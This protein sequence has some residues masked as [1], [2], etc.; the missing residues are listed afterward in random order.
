MRM[1]ASLRSLFSAL[2]R[3]SGVE[4]DM[5]EEL[6]T[7][8]QNRADDLERSGVPRSEAERRARIEFGGQERF[9]EEIREALGTHFLEV[10]LQDLRFGL[11]ML[12]KSPGFTAVAVLTLALGIGANTAIFSVVNAV[13]LRPMPFKDPGRLVIVWHTPPQKSFPGIATFVV[14]P[15]NF[16][17]WREQNHVFEQMT[18]VGFGNYNLTGMGQPE[19][20]SGVA[21]SSEFFPLLGIRPVF[22]RDFLPEEDQPGK[23]DVVIISNALCHSHF[24]D[25]H[26]ALGKT[27]LL[28]GH[29][30]LVIGVMP[31]QFDFPY[32]ADFWRPLAWSDKQR[33]VRGDH[34][35]YVFARL[36]Q[37]VTMH[38]AQ[39]EMDAISNRLAQQYPDDDAGWGAAVLPLGKELL[40]STQP[41]LLMLLGAVGFVILIACTNVANLTLAKAFA[42]RKEMAIRSAL[43]ASRARVIQQVLAETLLLSLAG[44]A[45]ALLL[46]HF[47]VESIS[48]IIQPRLPLTVSIGLD[49]WVLAF[50]LAL[51]VLTGILAGLAPSWHLTKT[52]LNDSLKEGLGKTDADSGGGKLRSAFVV[53]EV[54]LSLVLL[55]GA[56]LL[57]RTLIFLRSVDTGFDSHNVLTVPLG[58]STLKF[59]AAAQQINFFNN[60]LEDVRALPGVQSAGV[61]DSIPF[62]GGSTQPVAIEGQP[63]VAMADQP[64]VAVRLISPGYL[65]AM[66]IPLLQGR[67]FA[68]ADTSSSQPVILVSESFARRFWPNQN[69]FGK[70]VTLT[71]TPLPGGSR[72]V[73]GVVGDVK[74]RGLAIASPIDAIYSDMAQNPRTTFMN[75]VVRT[76][77]LPTSLISP[78]A[79][80]VHRVDPDTPVVNA[81]TMDEVVQNSLSQR[82]LNMWLL[83]SFA[84][85]ALLLAAVGIYGVQAYSARQRVR[86]IGIRMALGAKRSDVF[87][88]V[89]GQ[90]FRLALLGITIGLA[91][92]LLLTRFIESQ[93][94]GLKPTDPLTFAGVSVLLALVVTAACYIPARRATRVD[95]MVALRYE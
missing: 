51:S 3:R 67:D 38:Q 6:S 60:V 36:K 42:R 37:D 30:Y 24:G 11:R 32:Q 8:I 72:Q 66:R 79:D 71:F 45:L 62:R 12:R 69:P 59:P 78:V 81:L 26:N 87:L 16:L 39:S 15:A 52:N 65:S 90:G 75:L 47:L 74:L 1:I 55:A 93:L 4:A 58:I 49:V 31:T 33:A 53:A 9:K 14:S 23:G 10:L 83:A 35:Y 18:A 56:G 80:A 73:V 84:G 19:S 21:V 41:A 82:E 13:V 95:P 20:V 2:F 63:V 77:P 50:A 5:N 89:L 40:G 54:A 27:M 48:A 43:G 57:V 70:H 46:A 76:S 86:E 17:D 22:G 25:E 28:D 91:G 44:G 7:H 68:A 85:L 88:M 29:S 34:G 64:E 94:F 92:S 61:I